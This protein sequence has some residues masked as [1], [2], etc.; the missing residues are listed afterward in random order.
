MHWAV[1]SAAGRK[2][3]S[4]WQDGR[5]LDSEAPGYAKTLLDQLAWWA[6]AL[7]SAREATPYPA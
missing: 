1:F 6:G 3:T 2:T 5:P 7:R 4:C